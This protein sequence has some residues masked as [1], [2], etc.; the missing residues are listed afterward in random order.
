VPR[1]HFSF[2]WLLLWT[3]A[4]FRRFVFAAQAPAGR[5]TNV[6]KKKA[7]EKRRTPKEINSTNLLFSLDLGFFTSKMAI[8]QMAS[9][10][11]RPR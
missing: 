9:S 6:S 10:L 1:S 4:L 2:A 8:I 7:A 11:F 3:A 5:A